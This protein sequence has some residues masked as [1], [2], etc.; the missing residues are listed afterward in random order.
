MST[1]QYADQTYCIYQAALTLPLD[2]GACL[3]P[4]CAIA[5]TST[6]ESNDKTTYTLDRFGDPLT[7]TD[8]AGQCDDL[9]P[10][11]Q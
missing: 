4:T 2:N 10:Q 1:V 5:A 3:T 9:Y 7:V 8:A 6:D 11:C